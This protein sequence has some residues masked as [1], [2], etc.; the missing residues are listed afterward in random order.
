[1]SLSELKFVS[2]FY[3]CEAKGVVVE[4]TDQNY[5]Q[6]VREGSWMLVV[7]ASWCPHCKQL[8]PTWEKLAEKLEGKGI[9]VGQIDGPEQ[10]ILARRLQITG[11]PHIFHVDKQGK[12]RE[13]GERPRQLDKVRHTHTER[14]R[15]RERETDRQ[16]ERQIDRERCENGVYT[17]SHSTQV[18]SRHVF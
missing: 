13:Y 6:L 5:D 7:T 16:T 18:C 8:E 1:M 10:K 17:A 15:D 12:I 4:V 2:E 14:E 9:R 11:F 3:V